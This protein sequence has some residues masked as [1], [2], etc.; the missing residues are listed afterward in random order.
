M[1]TS[2]HTTP[3]NLPQRVGAWWRERRQARERPALLRRC[4]PATVAASQIPAAVR[5]AWVQLAPEDCP[6]L[7]VDDDAW[8]RCSLALAQFFEACRLQR[9]HGACALPSKAADSVWHVW[10]ATD[11][12]SL[13]AWQRRYFDLEV[14]HQEGAAL[15]APLDDCIART[16]VGA[17]TSEGLSPLGPRLPLVFAVDSMLAL[18]TGWAYRFERHGLVH[19]DID[20]FGRTHGSGVLH[21]AVAGTGLV[22]LGLLGEAELQ[23]WR[24][25]QQASSGGSACGGIASSDSGGDG[26]A[27][28]DGGSSGDC[29][30]SSCGGSGCG[31][32]GGS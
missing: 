14:P 24:R 15:G 10:L 20:G 32:G 22:G 19:R 1:D 30:G 12:A 4:P 16:W 13:A 9:V 3:L 27:S 7:R 26:C 11:P 31:G 23:A 28:S 8:L 18:P 29:G 25:Q 5:A 21:A 17:C 6:G 2:S